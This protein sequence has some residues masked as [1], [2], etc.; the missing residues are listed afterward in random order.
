MPADH[1]QII[2]FPGSLLQVDNYTVALFD[3]STQAD[4]KYT[5]PNNFLHHY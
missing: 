5:T 1:N 3:Q 2:F 4:L